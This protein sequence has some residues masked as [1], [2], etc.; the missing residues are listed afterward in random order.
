MRTSRPSPPTRA[1]ARRLLAVLVAGAAAV[2]LAAG[3]ATPAAAASPDPALARKLTAVM[4]DSRVRQASSATVVLDATSGATLYDRSGG[5]ALIPASNTK[6]L[7]AAAALHTLGPSYRFTTEVFRRG[8]VVKGTVRGRLYLKGYGDP[9]TREQDYRSLARQVRKAGITRVAG[10]LAVDVTFFDAQRYN[11]GWS[12]GYADDYY[13]AEISALTVAPNADL[14]AGTVLVN[15][16]PGQRGG[17]ARITTTPA[18]AARYVKIVNKTTTGS[19]SSSSTFSARRSHGSG[20]ITVSG[21]VPLG[22][23][24]ASTLITVHRPE[25][26]AAAVFRAELARAGV[27]V[28]GETLVVTALTS[29]RTR[30]ARDTSMK[31][32]DLLVPFLKLSNNMHAEALTKAMAARSG[33]PGSWPA[34]L[35]ITRAYLRSLGVPMRGVA[36]TDGSG[37]TRRNTVTARALATTLVKVRREPWFAAFD[38]ALPVAGDRRRMVGGTLRARMNGTRAAG[39]AHAKTGTL[40]GVTA[41]SGYVRGRD[42]RRYVF[43]MISNHRGASPRPVE[44]TLVVTLAGWR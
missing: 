15:Y 37:L 9:T 16:A 12:T 6:S 19:S 21:R 26:Y 43:A 42:G 23:G 11:P 31:L 34:G 32:S 7:T 1:G 2:A 44:N 14:D 8:P 35:K 24:R 28:E 20:T 27:A 41:L 10:P 18:S 29:Q 22:R 4:S 36:L 13:A 17:K 33:R 25:L 3:T 40:T 38:R 39:N 30:L 5:R